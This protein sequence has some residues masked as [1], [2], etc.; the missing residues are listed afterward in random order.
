MAYSER[1]W[2]S[3]SQSIVSRRKAIPSLLSPTIDFSILTYPFFLRISRLSTEDPGRANSGRLPPYRF[4]G[5]RSAWLLDE[6]IAERSS[7]CAAST[8]GTGR[9]GNMTCGHH[10]LPRKGQQGVREF[11]K[12]SAYKG[13]AWTWSGLIAPNQIRATGL[14][15]LHV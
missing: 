7:T 5:S 13:I 3:V 10:V 11:C 12:Q 14:S 6:K 4:A 2:L 1:K 8:T 15:M 9:L